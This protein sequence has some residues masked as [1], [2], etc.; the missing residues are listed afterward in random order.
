NRVAH[1]E[2]SRLAYSGISVGWTWGFGRA[3]ASHNIIESNFL[4]DIGQGML[5]DLGAIYMLG[6][7]KGSVVRRNRI[8]N[9]FSFAQKDSGATAWG[10]YLDEGSSD[11]LVEENLVSNTTGG[12]FHLHYGNK[13]IVR[14]NIFT[15]GKLAQARRSGKKDSTLLFERNVLAADEGVIYSGEWQDAGVR[16]HGNVFFRK[17]GRFDYRGQTLDMLKSKGFEHDSLETY[18]GQLCI[19]GNCSLPLADATRTGFK[20]FSV[21]KAGI[22]ERGL[23]LTRWLERCTTSKGRYSSMDRTGC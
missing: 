15:G 2:L 17:N 19:D 18:L 20:K 21:V 5:S 14:N 4:H 6:P 13:N 16:S 23:L 22:V 8:E 1:N 9:V 3:D 11:V 12:G 7:T 10:I